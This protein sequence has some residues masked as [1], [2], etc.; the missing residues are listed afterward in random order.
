MAFTFSVLVD[1]ELYTTR[2]TQQ[3]TYLDRVRKVNK[4]LN[5]PDIGGTGLSSL[6]LFWRAYEAVS[7]A[8]ITAAAASQEVVISGA[9]NVALTGEHSKI[10]DRLVLWFSKEH[11]LNASRIIWAKFIIVAPA[12]EIINTGASAGLPI[13]SEGETLTSAATKPEQLSAMIQYLASAIPYLAVDGNYYNGGW[14]YSATYSR[15]VTAARDVGGN[16]DT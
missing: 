9:D 1:D 10:S 2:L 12:D 15:L 11:P 4:L 14:A 16:P 6:Q 13:L 3:D 5:L 7:N 8:A